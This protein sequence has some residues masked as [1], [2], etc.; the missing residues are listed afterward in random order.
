MKLL[1][2]FKKALYDKEIWMVIKGAV[3]IL[4]AVFLLIFIAGGLSM[5]M[6]WLISPLMKISVFLIFP[7][8]V[9]IFAV[10]FAIVALVIKTIDVYNQE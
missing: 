8:L 9:V 1:A 6:L 7:A 4:L 3:L 10:L 2:A 5:F